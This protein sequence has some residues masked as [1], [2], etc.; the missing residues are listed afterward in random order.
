M[1]RRVCVVVSLI[2]I[3]SAAA[4]DSN[5]TAEPSV[6]TTST[7]RAAAT[8]STSPVSATAATTP[9]VTTGPA[10]TTASRTTPTAAVTPPELVIIAPESGKTV[11]TRTYRFEGI[12]EPGCT[13]TAAGRYEAN[14][15]A[16]GNFSIVLALNKGGNLATFVAND[17]SGNTTQVHVAVTYEPPFTSR[18]YWLG[19]KV[20]WERSGIG[21]WANVEGEYGMWEQAGDFIRSGW[22]L[23][24]VSVTPPVERSVDRPKESFIWVLE[25]DVI[26]ASQHVVV[27][28]GSEVTLMCYPAE[29]PSSVP[30]GL[31][32]VA[33]VT[34]GPVEPLQ[35][36][37]TGGAPLIDEL[38]VS[39]FVCNV[40]M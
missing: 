33:A 10:T 29:S 19:R 28:A 16:D 3:L 37:K 15:D 8:T 25:D 14:V 31:V 17:P 27:D 4:C 35:L 32:G 2:L 18:D 21:P 7:T 1:K 20:T 30:I 40:G 11:T 6:S 34:E 12:T 22:S 24:L 9:P 39:G 13:I 5:G 36:W 38:P 23:H 26:R